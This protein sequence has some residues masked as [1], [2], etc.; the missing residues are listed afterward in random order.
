MKGKA[1]V[2]PEGSFHIIGL[3]VLVDANLQVKTQNPTP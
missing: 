1:G 2:L 3:D